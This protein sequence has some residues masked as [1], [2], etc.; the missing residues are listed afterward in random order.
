MKSVLNFALAISVMALVAACGAKEEP[1]AMSL[2]GQVVAVDTGSIKS[3][4]GPEVG[5][6]REALAAAT[7]IC[8][9]TEQEVA[10]MSAATKN[11]LKKEGIAVAVVEVLESIPQAIGETQAATFG[12]CSKMLAWYAAARHGGQNHMAATNGIRGI[13]KIVSQ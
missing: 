2:A 3:E 4:N 5:R 9:I 13:L 6:A 1:Q 10:D 12:G 7:R 8:K 11:I